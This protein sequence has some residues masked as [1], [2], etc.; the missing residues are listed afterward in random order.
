MNYG[1][2]VQISGPV[3]D[4]RFE[5]GRLPKLREALSVTAEGETASW[6]RRSI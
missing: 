1:R 2:I 5:G 6:K 3:V 4:V